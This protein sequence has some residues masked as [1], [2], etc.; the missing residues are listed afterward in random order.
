MAR[1]V[2]EGSDRLLSRRETAVVALVSLVI[3]LLQ[4]PGRISPDTKLDLTADPI[5]FLARAAHLW[6]PDAPMGQIQNQAYGY[7]F[8]HGLFFAVGEVLHVP[9]WITQRFWWALLLTVGFIGVVRLAEALRVGSFGSRLIAAWAFVLAPRVM[10]TLGTISSETLPMMLAPW[11]LLPVVRALDRPDDALPLWRHAARS[12]CA[13]ALMGAVNAVATA[14]AVAVSVIWWA[15]ATVGRDGDRR[16]RGLVFGGW[17]GAG[18]VLACIWWIVPLLILSRVSPPFLDFIESAGVTTEWTSLTE[19]LRGTD[20]WTPFVSPERA[21]GAVLVSEPAAVIATGVLAA[22]GLAGLTMRALPHRRRLVTILVVGLLAL[23]LG[24]PGALGSPIRD[25]VIAFLDGSGAALRNVHKFDPLI[26]LPLALGIAHLLARVRLPARNRGTERGFAAAMVVVIAAFGTGSLLWT[27]GLAPA[28]SYRAIPDYWQQ[29]ADWLDAAQRDSATPSRALV[30][31]G[32]PFADQVWGLTR[33]EPLQALAQSPWAVRDAIPLT[34]PGAIRVMDSVQRTLS[35]GRGSPGLANA[36][37]EQGIGYLVLRADLDPA[38][39]RSARPLVVAQAIRNSP[40]LSEAAR[41]GPE[42]APPTLDGVVV[43]DGLRP[44][45]PAVTIYRVTPGAVAGQPG[46]VD[47][48]AMSRVS[49][50]PEALLSVEDSRRRAGLDPLGPALLTADARRAGLPDRPEIV[51]DTPVDRETDFGRVDDHSSAIRAPD[52]PRLTKNAAPDY[53]VDGQPLVEAQWLL[54]N[55]PGQVRVTSSGSASDATQPGRTS[56]ANSTA[57]AFDGDPDIAWV[58]RGL[59]SAVGRWLAVGFTQ[60][61]SDLAVTVTTANA[62]GPDVSTILLSTDAGS[63]VATGV[64]PGVPTRILAPSGPTSNVQIRAIDTANGTAGNQFAI[65]ELSFADAN[66]D[67]PLAIRQRTVLPTL[68]AAD[69]VSGWVLG[70]ELGPA[71]DCVT[72]GDGRVR[73]S[74]ALGLNSETPGVFGRTLSVPTAADVGVRVTLRPRA[75]GELSDLL[76]RTGTITADGSSAVSDPLGNA[77]AA[78]DGDPN[79][80]WTAPDPGA[81]TGKKDRPS[82]TVR[83]PAVREV[84]G[85]RLVA[86]QDYP[87]RPTRVT[88][89]LREGGRTVGRTRADVG[90]DGLIS[91]PARRADTVVLTIEKSSDL[92]DVDDLGFAKDAPVGISEVQVLPGGANPAPDDQRPIEIRCDTDASGPYGLGVTASGQVIRLQVQTTAGAL[93]RGEPIPATT[94]PG[95]PLHLAAGEQEVSVNPGQAFTV[96]AVTLRPVDA[97]ATTAAAVTRPTVDRWDQTDRLVHVDAGGVDRVLFVPESTNPGWHARV[98]GR[99]LAPIVVNGWQQGWIVPAGTAG[100]VALTFDLDTPYRWAIGVGLAL[101]VV[102]FA[103]AFWPRRGKPTGFPG[104]LASSWSSKRRSA[105]TTR[106]ETPPTD[107]T[108]HADPL[109]SPAARPLRGRSTRALTVAATA[110]ALTASF[111]LTGWPGAL[112]A[113]AA[114]VVAWRLPARL[115]PVFSFGAMLAATVVLASGPWHS[116]TP[117]TGY[118]GWGQAFALI[119]VSATVTSLFPRDRAGDA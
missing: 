102:L 118:S 12:A 3:C 97:P 99:E 47:V 65:S 72:A 33:D 104:R 5:G 78:V 94:C 74:A 53:P 27:G 44:P 15:L 50:G 108:Q 11:V 34:P 100:T 18:L 93:R 77:A 25:G 119:A 98:D 1:H 76:A 107:R 30:V 105:A 106:I 39:S 54:D 84:S 95:P 48:D 67:V 22:A 116:G 6:S 8:P 31:P 89:E 9:P 88:V 16:R 20:S 37:A 17:W 52:D 63:T 115:R 90:R 68:D 35:S 55:Q 82:L 117:Y 14:A 51:T 92:I 41:F 13:V 60:P 70:P 71:S 40:G 80:T 7:F 103:V 10:T 113:A 46:L 96:D 83:L 91:V 45:M 61:R 112:I 4:R 59:E 114:G 29:T 21:V 81:S 86:P 109:R 110:T 69:T 38:T 73:C 43:D 75:S 79:T 19:V 2:A 87:A 111:L 28:K 42:V 101:V 56:P 26:R 49:G 85:L 24:Y 32:A 58:S 23:C 64:K 62:L 66:T 57:A 36:L